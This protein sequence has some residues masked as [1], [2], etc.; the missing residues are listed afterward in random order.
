MSGINQHKEVNR[1][2]ITVDQNGSADPPTIPLRVKVG[3]TSGAP[4]RDYAREAPTGNSTSYAMRRLEKAPEEIR[5][6]VRSGE[7]KPTGEMSKA[8]SSAV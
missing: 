4:K 8:A 1:D 7:L 6:R 5:E 3:G 2:P